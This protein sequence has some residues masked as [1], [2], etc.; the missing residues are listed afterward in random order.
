MTKCVLP[1][2]CALA[3]SLLPS[4][5]M[6]QVTTPLGGRLVVSLNGIAQPGDQNISS[7]RSFDRYEE[8][9]TV[10]TEQEI[11]S[12]SGMLDFGAAVQLSGPFGVGMA[13]TS[14]DTQRG[15]TVTGS[16]PHPL[17][18]SAS[19]PF[20]MTLDGLEHRQRAVHLQGVM[21]IPFI[22]NVDFMVSAGPT[23]FTMTQ[24]VARF[25][26]FTEVGPPHTDVNVTHAI[27]R[28]RE[29][30]VGFNIGADATYYVTR[31]IGIGGMLR[32]TRGSVDFNLGD[33]HTFSLDAGNVQAGAGLRLRF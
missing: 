4:G 31:M 20:S 16:L 30:T 15:A 14:F 32:Y 23:F 5:A 33:G 10:L 29:T 11:K 12:G 26:D 1:A 18:F 19:R 7:S 27:V 2:V 28:S 24:A 9:A 17:F 22:E 21:F 6:A 13:F 8:T 25:E 3:F